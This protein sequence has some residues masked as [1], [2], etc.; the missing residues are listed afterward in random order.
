MKVKHLLIEMGLVVAL[1]MPFVC[2]ATNQKMDKA[3]NTANAT[4]LPGQMDK[5][6]NATN[7]PGQVDKAAIEYEYFP[8]RAHAFVWRN[9]TL[10][11]AER[12]AQVMGTSTRKVVRM[13]KSMGLEAKPTVDP[14]W[15]SEKGYITVL[16]RNWHLLPYEQLLTLL[17]LS[18]EELAW[19]LQEDDFLFI[20]LGSIKP[21]CDPLTY[22]RPNR[23]IRKR[24][25]E[26]RKIVA[27]VTA[28]REPM[29]P[30]FDLFRDA[31]TDLEVQGSDDLRMVFSYNAEYGDPLMDESQSSYSDDL[32]ACLKKQGI[33]TVWV[34]SVLRMLV[35]PDG[36]YPGDSLASKRIANLK[37]LVDRAKKY[38][39]DV[40]LYVN[41]P[42]AMP[43]SW[44][45]SPERQAL[46]GASEAGMSTLCTSEPATL[47]WLE[48]SFAKVF[49]QVEGLGGVF[50]ITASENLTSCASHGLMSSCPRCRVREYSDMIADVNNAI[51]AGVRRSSPDARVIVWDWG[52]NDSV[53]NEIIDK[54]SKDCML[55]SVSEWSL[56][57]ERGGISTAVGEYSISAVGP[58]PRA[59][60]HWEHARKAGLKT[61]A[62]V[63]AN[64]TWELGSVP[65]VPALG[66]ITDH[67]RK[68]AS[69]NVDGVMM[70]WS[71]GGYPSVNLA[72]FGMLMSN[73]EL[74]LRDIA[75]SL[76][77]SNI[78]SKVERA[79]ELF[80]EG[81]SEYPYHILSVYAG[82]HHM[83]VANPFFLKPTGYAAS[84]V[85]LPYDDL[86]GWISVYPVETY[87]SQFQALCKK[88]EEG[89][90]VLESALE[91]A[92]E[93][94]RRILEV[95]ILRAKAIRA[96]FSS[97][98]NQALFTQSRNEEDAEGMLSAINAE[99]AL[100]SEYLDYVLSDPTLG[101]ESSNQYFFVPQ[102]IV[103]KMINLE[104]LK[105]R[106]LE[107]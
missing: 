69:A 59:E 68:L 15:L 83:G 4:N 91:D 13:A 37:T 48:D 67:A 106:L 7:L 88:F 32:L 39:I 9:W 75:D 76:Y 11:P 35:E 21:K 85:G 31:R 63:M 62:K 43:E 86:Q 102:D 33:N 64:T 107:H 51:A 65:S 57:L 16:R 93:S 77:G 70:S 12:L 96:H 8:T 50:T 82:P 103:E 49:S 80:S 97:T 84:M 34:H 60:A 94:Q 99:E 3:A 87:V 90:A 2:G 46:I 78:G 53:A 89:V 104:H 5:A 98:I 79:W 95:D 81:Y 28:G 100:A 10:V 47:K 26:I 14:M 52:W 54:L 29:V 55:M 6:A 17:D 92:D 18:E 36:V 40:L 20:K 42:R 22:S 72:A 74:S 105:T 41:E 44:F 45:D 27:N 30:R 61:V 101:Y 19:R 24:T 58:G 1:C 25:K 73:P 66:L 71:L 56:P 38:G 23:D